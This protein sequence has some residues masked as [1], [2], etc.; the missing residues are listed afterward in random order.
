MY[1]EFVKHEIARVGMA[2]KRKLTAPTPRRV[3]GRLPQLAKNPETE[4]PMDKK[5]IHAICKARCYVEAEHDPWQ[6][7]P[8]PAQ[9]NLPSELKV[10]RTSCARHI[11]SHFHAGSWY[12]HVAIDPCYSL[13]PRKLEKL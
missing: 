9:D 8:N 10:P 4:K 11:L 3:R 2:M 7:L 6:Y 1:S 12:G 5:T 13:L